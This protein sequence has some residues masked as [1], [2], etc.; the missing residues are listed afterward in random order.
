MEIAIPL[1]ALSGLF[2]ASRERNQQSQQN[3]VQ[4]IPTENFQS[5][6]YKPPSRTTE[7]PN[8]NVP[9]RNYPEEYPIN[10][11]TQEL[12]RTSKLTVDNHFDSP[13]VYTDKYFNQNTYKE[14]AGQTFKSMTGETVNSSYFE[15]NNMTPYFGSK[16]RSSILEA[17]SMES[18]LDNYVGS[19]TQ[20]I[21]KTETSPLFSPGENYHHPHG[22]P[23]QNDFFQ[24][25]V[26]PS[27]RMANMKPFESQ[28]V[29][30]GL[31]L[32]GSS[33]A[34]SGGFNSGMEMRE[35]WMPKSVDE[36]RVD[37]NKRAGG[38]GLLGHEGPAGHMTKNMGSI[39]KV[40]KNRVERA[41]DHGPERYFT[42]TGVEK[43]PMM[44][45]IPLMK[46][47]SRPET[48]ASYV[49]N[50]TT[51]N[52][53]TMMPG[54]YMESKHM[55]LGAVPLGIASSVGHK[56]ATTGD[57][58][59]QSMHV[60]DNNRTTTGDETYFGAFSGAIGAVIAPL[61]DE[62]RPSRKE[63]AVGTMRPY[64]NAQSKV[65]SSYIFNP[66]DRPAPTIRE[67]TE[68]NN[69]VSGVNK[70]QNG[71]AYK[72]T[73][74]QAVRNERDTTSVS[75]AGGS[76]AGSG[77]L[78]ARTYDSAYRQR[79]NDIKSS[80]IKGHMVK[81]STNIL[82]THMN[83][84]NRARETVNARQTVAT[85]GPRQLY[86]PS[87]YGN[88]HSKQ[89]YNSGIQLDRNTPDMTSM[90]KKNPYVQSYNP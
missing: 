79:N 44:H 26:N 1:V 33:N 81:G 10:P 35:A 16:N 69:F 52:P 83:A 28:Q 7:L 85:D 75:Y 34:G 77:T 27:M 50:A 84:T 63:N 14:V 11:T 73:P 76:S 42:T 88:L 51:H 40:E 38:I 4:N 3:A 90:L 5:A 72:T 23:N 2:I 86:G 62:L 37:N 25:R 6:G 31:G 9:N 78:A 48:T 60:Y 41:W 80:T 82:N 61:L 15:H 47:V 19:G 49:G 70:N 55:D 57:Y 59:H 21:R 56:Q 68:R 43:G 20:I 30:P 71:G 36:L 54:E 29:G 87:N 24:E 64:Q 66:A 18:T 89:S 46:D 53:A 32:G 45:S 12:D 65:G 67:T 22:A 58:G 17:D 8:T 74:H 13:S 39:G